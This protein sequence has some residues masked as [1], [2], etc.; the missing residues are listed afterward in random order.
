MKKGETVSVKR[1][2]NRARFIANCVCCYFEL[3]VDNE[4]PSIAIS[5]AKLA[6]ELVETL[7]TACNALPSDP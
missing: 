4:S 3:T 7:E 1:L 5:M 6:S 2:L